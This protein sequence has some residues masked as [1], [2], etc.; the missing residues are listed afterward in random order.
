[1]NLIR[2]NVGSIFIGNFILAN[3]KNKHRL[4]H[5]TSDLRFIWVKNKK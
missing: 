2:F 3:K 1:M 4:D 5:L